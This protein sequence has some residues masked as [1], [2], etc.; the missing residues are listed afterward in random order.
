M[1]I[2]RTWLVAASP[3]PLAA[4]GGAAS[5]LSPVLLLHGEDDPAN[6]PS[7]CEGLSTALGKA[8]PVRRIS[9]RGASYAWDLPQWGEG[10]HSRQRWPGGQGTVAVRSWP[11]LAE[12]T[13]AQ[14]AAFLA[15][16]LSRGEAP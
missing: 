16:T 5:V 7:A 13:A 14:A 1:T 11:E 6:P 2:R 12:L 10:E 4:G 3:F 15:D 8:A 9:H